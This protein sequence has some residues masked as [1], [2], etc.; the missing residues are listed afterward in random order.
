M[1]S[2]VSSTLVCLMYSSVSLFNFLT[3]TVALASSFKRSSLKPRMMAEL[4]A[5]RS[6]ISCSPVAEVFPKRS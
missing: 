5:L 3:V 4:I 6:C 1:L 2:H